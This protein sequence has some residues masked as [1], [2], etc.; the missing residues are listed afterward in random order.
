MAEEPRHLYSSCRITDASMDAMVKSI[1]VYF[2]NFY[3]IVRWRR[4]IRKIRSRVSNQ[5]KNINGTINLRES[6]HARDIALESRGAEPVQRS[7]A[8][9]LVSHM[10]IK[11][12]YRL[13]SAKQRSLAVMLKVNLHIHA[14]ANFF[15]SLEHWLNSPYPHQS[16]HCTFSLFQRKG[17]RGIGSIRWLSGSTCVQPDCCMDVILSHHDE[18][19]HCLKTQ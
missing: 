16:H 4:R 12:L 7:S 13:L 17:D 9:G 6:I 15:S 2:R 11:I 10:K 1:I 18:Y 8:P 19:S 3:S 14:P 5:V